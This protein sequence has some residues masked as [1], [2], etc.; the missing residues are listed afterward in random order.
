VLAQIHGFQFHK[1]RLMRQFFPFLL[2]PRDAFVQRGM[3]LKRLRQ[4]EEAFFS[5]ASSAL[6]FLNM[7]II[8]R[9]SM[10]AC[11]R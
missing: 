2:Q 1:P 7:P 4:L 11:T 9:G 10:F 5:F 8:P 6:N 3:A